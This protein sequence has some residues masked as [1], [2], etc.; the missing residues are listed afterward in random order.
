MNIL[1]TGHSGFIGSG[2]AD[3]FVE[4]GHVVYGV[5]RSS[6]SNCPHPQ[7][8]VDVTDKDL[9]AQLANE[10]CIDTII[11]FAGK[12]LVIDCDK[13]PYNAFKI[14]GLGTAAVLEAARYAGVKKS[15]IIE[16]DKVYGFQEEVPTPETAVLN[17]GSP[18]E[19]SK[20]MAAQFCDFYRTHYEMDVVS[21][22][23]V[24]VFGPGDYSYTRIMP[25]SLRHITSGEGI[26][27]HEHATKMYRDFIYI[28]DVAKMMYI[29]ATQ[30]TKHGVYNFSTNESM[31]ILEFAQRVTKA[32]NY[33]VEPMII[34]KPGEYPEIPYQSID[35]SRFA[36]E[37]DFKFTSFEDA[38]VET[39]NE[40]CKTF[41][42]P[43]IK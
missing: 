33:S 28:K 1:I 37:F 14:N 5:S 20:A 7:Y 6:R 19:L 31:S 38:T 23:P 24:N 27:V 35:G 4:Q 22:R 26:P 25:N 15:I 17:P 34:K 36:E 8:N 10:K 40:Y 29:L 3:Y 9:L 2:T 16:T 21:V 42:L 13:D 12:P 18:Y 32:L 41:N 39:Y 43:R 11:H 30:E